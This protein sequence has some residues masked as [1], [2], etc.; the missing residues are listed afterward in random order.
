MTQVKDTLATLKFVGLPKWK[1]EK[2]QTSI[3][4]MSIG[5]LLGGDYV[6]ELTSSRSHQIAE[7]KRTGIPVSA[8]RRIWFNLLRLNLDKEVQMFAMAQLGG[9]P[10]YWDRIA[11][12]DMARE[13]I[14]AQAQLVYSPGGIFKALS[15]VDKLTVMTAKFNSKTVHPEDIEAAKP[16]KD[17]P[18]FRNTVETFVSSI[19]EAH[20]EA[21]KKLLDLIH[22]E[23]LQ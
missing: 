10:A 1:E 9:S 8:M 19:P 11:R 12:D 14:L 5:K 15:D 21:L 6:Y 22:N 18:L 20:K 13:A 3:F 2:L 16:F 7:T 17:N 4:K 23:L